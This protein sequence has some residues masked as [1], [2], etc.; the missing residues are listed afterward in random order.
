MLIFCSTAFVFLSHPEREIR[1]HGTPLA[2][3]PG[4]ENKTHLLQERDN[5]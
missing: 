4:P 5:E 1:P 2:G 3:N